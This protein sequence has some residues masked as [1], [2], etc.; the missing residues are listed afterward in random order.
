ML[1][2]KMIRNVILG[3]ACSFML[4]AALPAAEAG[5]GGS[6]GVIRSAVRSNNAD[7][8]ISAMEQS[9]NIPCNTECMTMVMDLFEND[10]YRIRQVAAWWIA[11]RPAQMKEAAELATAWLSLDD[12]VKA[13]NGA[14][15]LGTFGYA[16]YIPVLE[17]AVTKP[18][19]T[20][21]ARAAAVQ[22]LGNI[23]NMGANDVVG[24]AMSDSS[25]SVRLNAVVA[26]KNMLKQ[27][28]AQPVVALVADSD[29]KVRR[30]AVATVG[31]FRVATARASLEAAVVGDSDAALRRNAAWA[32]GRI[33]DAASREAL[34]AATTDE[35]SMVR[36]TAKVALAKLR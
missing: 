34:F 2:N 11:R 22:A 6:D 18:G 14:D 10:D 15:I 1:E 4:L 9:E 27:T 35:S 3:A 29:V 30:A 28:D 31:N 17:A 23:G 25:A 12:S 19:F 33:G 24:A 5:R 26:W 13:R 7:A 21:E 16:K 20:A 8:I 36:M 32:L